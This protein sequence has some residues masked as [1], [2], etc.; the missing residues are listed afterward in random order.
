[1]LVYDGKREGKPSIK[2]AYE[3]TRKKH[4]QDKY[5]AGLLVVGI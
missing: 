3:A 5:A 1:M 2:K 4:I